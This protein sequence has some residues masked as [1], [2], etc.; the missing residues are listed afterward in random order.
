MLFR[1]ME[2]IGT[3]SLEERILGIPYDTYFSMTTYEELAAILDDMGDR[4]VN[5]AYKG[6]F[7]GGMNHKLMN[8]G[9]LVKTNGEKA[10]LDTLIAKVEGA[11][12]EIFLETDFLKIYDKGNGFVKWLHGLED[13]SKSVVDIYGYRV[14]LGIFKQRSNMYNLLDPKYIVDVVAD[15]KENAE[16][17]YNY[18][19]N[20][21]TEHYYADYGNEYVSP[22]EAQRLLDTAIDTL[23]KDSSLALDNP[24]M[25]ALAGGSV[26]VDVSRES[27]E[28]TAFYTSI[29]FRQLVLNGMMKYT[30][31]SAN[32]NSDPA[33]Y[34]LMQAIETGAQPKFTV[35]AKNVDVLKDSKYSYYFSVQ[36]DLMK[37]EI[38]EVYDKLAEA[39]ELIG[40]T[41]IVNHTMLDKDVFL[42]EYAGGTKVVTNYTFESFE[43]EGNVVE[44]D[45]YLIMKGG[46]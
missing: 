7:D 22:Y 21:L 26:A 35:S 19:V 25:D 41:K 1:S 4:H 14:E 40:T 8:S 38:K 15:F 11:G 18:Y 12:D 23:A 44:A 30:T 33:S 2:T 24:R 27:S 10:A 17:N 28:L 39:M 29:P 13:Y 34:Y 6:V 9:K 20:D 16:G 36:Y 32:N 5:I 43:Y 45:N 46:E 31:T 3:L 42:T 37:D